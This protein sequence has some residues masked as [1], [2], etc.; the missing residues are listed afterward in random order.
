MYE[1]Y[2]YERFCILRSF[3][4]CLFICFLYLFVSL[5]PQDMRIE[6]VIHFQRGLLP[7]Y[8]YI[9]IKP[10]AAI[11]MVIFHARN[12]DNIP[13]LRMQC[14]VLILEM[15][16]VT[17]H[18]SLNRCQLCSLNG[19]STSFTHRLRETNISHITI[20]AFLKSFDNLDL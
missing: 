11:Y 2:I 10:Y 4:I 6:A 3:L 5:L 8:G 7:S 20:K 19:C 14:F 16:R 1:P 9:Y 17:K 18:L 13:V 12:Y 15:I